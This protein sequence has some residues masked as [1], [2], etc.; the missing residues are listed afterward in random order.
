MHCNFQLFGIR[1]F[2]L[3]IFLAFLFFPIRFNAQNSAKNLPT[4]VNVLT[5]ANNNK[6]E[7]DFKNDR[8]V[9]NL[10]VII[11]DSIGHT[12]FLQ[13]LYR[14]KGPYKKSVDLKEAGKGRYTLMIIKDEEKIYKQ[15]NM[16]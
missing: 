2:I 12:V 6:V 10:L 15:I 1:N 14:F 3:L 7:I 8:E 9:Q 5:D 16:P 11:T 4:T 13:N